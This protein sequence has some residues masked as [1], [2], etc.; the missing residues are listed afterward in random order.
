MKSFAL[1]CVRWRFAVVGVWLLVLAGLA[2]SA[3]GAGSKFATS[4]DLP[5]S[6]SGT[7][8]SLLAQQGNP[9]H[10]HPTV[11]TGTIAWHS[12]GG[13]IDSAG[14]K[15]AATVML[16]E[17]KGLP[18]VASVVGPYD[19]PAQ[20]NVKAN[21]AYA[22][23]TVTDGTDPAGI[24]QTAERL[25]GPTL[26]VQTG[27][28]AFDEAPAL[29]PITEAIGLLVALLV[30]LLVF[31]S[32]W[33][34]LLPIITGVA[35]VGVS[36]LLAILASHVMD[37]D[38][39]SLTMGALIGLGVGIDYALFIVNRFRKA[40][41]TGASVPE[42]I[43]LALNTS[44]RAVI[45]AGLTVMIALLGMF[46]VNLGILT[47]MSRVAAATVLVTVLAAI[48]LLPALLGMLGHRILS[49]KQRAGLA[50]HALND[51]PLPDPHPR[52]A[53]WVDFIQR[54]PRLLGGAGLLLI[55]AMAF[56]ALSMRVGDSDA[57]S[58]PT[59]SATH[60]H[61]TIMADGFGAG[62]DS[63][64]QL[65]GRTPDAASRAAFDSLV[66]DLPSVQGVAL[67][68]AAPRAATGQQISV[69]TVEPTT[70]AQ[71]EQTTEL[72]TA[73][74]ERVIP[75]VESGT[76][77]KVYV[78]GKTAMAIDLAGALT[79][80]LPLYLGLIALLGFLLLTVAFRS[81]VLPLIA[82]V[83]NL[84]TILVSLGAVTAL[85]QWGWATKLLGVGGAAP[86]QYIAPT[87]M[88]GIM[89]GLSMDYQ[90]FL[91]SRVSEEWNHT[92]DN[93][94][95]VKV[96]VTQTALV[97]AA[98][99][100]IMFAIFASFGF[101]GQRIIAMIGI[102][103]TVGVLV[104][105][106]IIR[107]TIMPALMLLLGKRIWYFPKWADR[108]TPNISLEGPPAPE[109]AAA[110]AQSEKLLVGQRLT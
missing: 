101:S 34:A 72:V 41:M 61:Y 79:S 103:L 26:D 25:R 39:N 75:P 30:L 69:V 80:K 57:S 91:G 9:A 93:T 97:I 76:N 63:T 10:P 107:M 92:G 21:T 32:L 22:T 52:A 36:L 64:L 87:L 23:V 46:V 37:L 33:A 102:G 12:N 105:A 68:R 88:V 38:T 78:G 53:R 49:R 14:V 48:T 73:L 100:T 106:F 27:G 94:R 104:D 55:V 56:P 71:T 44:G 109:P 86:I 96:G 24:I 45:F 99:A 8:S 42:S 1:R 77:L 35:G 4:T 98:A 19:H 89:F 90:V 11:T 20:L 81:V 15:Q 17:V 83:S 50:S 47:G 2:V 59:G 31:R 40:L 51:P 7:A 110:D 62:Y 74:R 18:G 29:S 70:S 66:A 43:S 67:V 6:E 3:F 65:V 108:L 16:G 5:H 85:F 13:P 82:T 84:V 58:S 60:Q 54:R 28:T 95:A